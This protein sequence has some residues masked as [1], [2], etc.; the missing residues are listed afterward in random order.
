MRTR[1]PRKARSAIL[2]ALTLV[3]A[4]SSVLIAPPSPAA[5]RTLTFA[6]AADTTVRAD[7]P[8]ATGGFEKSLSADNSP[9]RYSFMR[10]TVAGIGTDP[11]ESAKLRLYVT[12]GASF[13]GEF[14]RVAN[15]TWSES[16][17]T[18]NSAPP[19]DSPAFAMLGPIVAGTWYEVDLSTLV[20]G[21]GQFGLRIATPASNK[22]SFRSKEGALGVR[23][24]LVVAVGSTDVVAP[25]ASIS[26]PSPGAVVN[27]SVD[28]GV[29]AA[30]GVGVVSVDLQVDGQT[31]GSDATA[32]YVIPWDSSSAA[33]GAHELT[34]VARD[35][36]GNAGTSQPVTVL[37]DN[38]PDTAPPT[39]PTGLVAT[40]TGPTR[41]ELSW[42]A[43]QDDV[44]VAGYAI[45]RDGAEIDTTT[46]TTYVDDGVDAETTYRFTVVAVDPSGNRSDPSEPAEV[47]TPVAPPTPTSFTF[48]AAGDAGTTSRATASLAALDASATDFFLA[49]GDLGYGEVPNE[50]AWCDFVK[51]GLPT[52]GP[53][54][55]FQLVAGN[56]EDQDGG[57]GYI[58]NYAA[59][60]PDRMGST[61]GPEQTYAA[62][63]YFDYPAG[64]PLMRVFMISPDLT[65]ENV[66]YGYKLDDANYR[67]LSDSIDAARAEGIRWVV[68]GMHYPCISASNSGCP[69]GQPLFNLLL[70]KRVDLVLAGHHHN[71]QR[72]KQLALA[73]GTCP[74]FVIGAFDQDCVADSGVGVME[75]GAGTVVQVVGTF[76]RSGSSIKADPELPYFVTTAG[77]GNGI[78]EYTVTADRLDA[79]F[80]PSVGSVSDSFTISASGAPGGDSTPPSAPSNLVATPVGGDRV[81]LGWTQSADDVGVDHY[82]VIRNGVAVGTTTGTT[83]LDGSLTP[84]SMYQYVVRAVDHAGNVSA[85][86]NTAV[87]TTEPGSELTFVPT[88]DATIRAGSPTTNYG[89]SS[90]LSIDSS[91]S[92]HAMMKFSVSGIGARTVA[93]AKLRLFDTGASDLG[94]VF[95]ATSDTSWTETGVTWDNAPAAVGQPVATLG[96]VGTNTWYEADLSS[97]IRSDGV[98]SI[99][100]STTSTDGVKWGSRDADAEFTPRLVITLLP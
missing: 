22:I 37:V 15:T 36:A 76:G 35:A 71:Y 67:W 55:P 3:A 63:Y 42:S 18:W 44:G 26:S 49:L 58:L 94:G 8:T 14:S 81:D 65:I 17:M 54:Y 24:E 83:F 57:D 4:A 84:G 6:P 21:D 30:D 78:M 33:N 13:G 98:Y 56:H 93:T 23:P 68:V 70:E 72:S 87:A 31:V 52:L 53:N 95:S 62:E 60:L 59:C 38:V 92:E 77:T 16:T 34:A 90:S 85:P 40:A 2:V 82:T 28:V 73:P 79:T 32:P 45:S 5:P 20:T 29:D 9:A 47:T 39:A 19:A 80:V 43:S 7:Q 74:S 1:R 69:I 27:G 48:A 86:S 11:V 89:T 88:A 46:G 64:A 51:S 61:L 75:K 100:I 41:V 50:A 10:F 66:T 12:D 96:S 91:P 99:R 97:L 25:T